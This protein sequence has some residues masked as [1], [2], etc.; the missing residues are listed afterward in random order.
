MFGLKVVSNNFRIIYGG[1][2]NPKNVKGFVGL[3][4]LD[5]LLVGAASLDVEKFYKVAKSIFK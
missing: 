1:S 4:N 5:G 3:E 2:I